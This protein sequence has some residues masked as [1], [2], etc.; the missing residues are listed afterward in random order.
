VDAVPQVWAKVKSELLAFA[1]FL[2]EPARPG[3]EV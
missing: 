1:G 3:G 2:D